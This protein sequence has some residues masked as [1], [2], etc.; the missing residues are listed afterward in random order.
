MNY[1]TDKELMQSI[2]MMRRSGRIGVGF[3]R[4]MWYQTTCF[5]LL[6]VHRNM[7]VRSVYATKWQFNCNR[8]HFGESDVT[9][10]W[11]PRRNRALGT[12]LIN[13]VLAEARTM[14]VGF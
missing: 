1:E 9:G 2:A 7:P 12:P 8:L 10:R 5:M 4:G 13:I 3:H 14:L 6:E 11:G